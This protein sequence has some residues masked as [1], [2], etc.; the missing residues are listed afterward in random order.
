MKIATSMNLDLFKTPSNLPFLFFTVTEIEQGVCGAKELPPLSLHAGVQQIIEQ[1]TFDDLWV[2]VNNANIQK[3]SE[4][5]HGRLFAANIIR[6]DVARR[7]RRAVGNILIVPDVEQQT[8]FED[9]ISARK[10]HPL[11]KVLVDP[12][13]QPNELRSTYWKIKLSA[14]GVPVCVDGGL[15]FS[16]EGFSCVPTSKRFSYHS[17]FSRGFM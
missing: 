17:Y 10:I 2:T 9:Q 5:V 16:P 7:S 1:P 4:H 13:L 14:D 12:S 6:N 15:Q 3:A 8:W 11:D